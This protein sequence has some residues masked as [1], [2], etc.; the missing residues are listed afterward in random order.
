VVDTP[1]GIVAGRAM[2]IDDWGALVVKCPGGIAHVPATAC[3]QAKEVTL[4]IALGCAG[5]FW[6]RSWRP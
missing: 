4:W 6:P 2:E 3:R 5:S 1:L